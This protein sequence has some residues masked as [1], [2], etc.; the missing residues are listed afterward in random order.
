MSFK[1]RKIRKRPPL[2]LFRKLKKKWQRLKHIASRATPK[3]RSYMVGAVL[4]LFGVLV[5]G[6]VM[7]ATFNFIR[8][9]DL[10]EFIFSIGTELKKDEYGYTNIVLLGG[11]GHER[12]DGADLVD[13]IM[14]ASIDYSKNA[15]TL[16]SIPRDYYLKSKYHT[17]KI[18]ELYRDNEKEIGE[19][20]AYALYQNASGEVANLDV[21]YYL[22]VDFN[23]F[24]EVVDSL[25]G[26]T[27]DVKEDLHDPYYPNETDNGYTTFQIKAGPQDLDGETALKFV[28]SRKTTSDF[29]RAMRQQQVLEAIRE[30]ALSKKILTSPRAIKNLYS[31]VKNNINTNLTIR[32]IIALARF[33]KGFNRDHLVTK[34]IHDDASREG[35][36]LYTPERKYYNNQFILLPYGDNLDTIHRYTN[37]IFH[38]RTIFSPPPRIEILNATHRP[39]LARKIAYQLNRFGFDMVKIDNLFDAEGERKYIETSIMH[40]YVYETDKDGNITPKFKDT[41]EVLQ[42]FINSAEFI[43]GDKANV[44]Q[45]IDLTIIIGEDYK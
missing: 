12:A 32:E 40:Y 10:R 21:Q 20:A 44:S 6:K 24:V 23:A 5:V 29:D 26:V 17:G 19:E 28:R 8:D 22:R 18:N 25:D 14:V 7:W 38:K 2:R 41:L 39:G 36:F 45:G 13:T 3:Q 11:S 30:K 15:V 37:L 27:V 42:D 33:A 1:T 4:V 35:G 16:F 31:A 34:I 43:P 9:F